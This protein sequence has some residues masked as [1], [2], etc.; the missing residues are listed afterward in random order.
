M[1]NLNYIS[2]T[3]SSK[4]KADTIKKPD[5]RID[6]FKREPLYFECLTGNSG[7]DNI[8]SEKSL[9]RPQLALAG[10]YE[11][12]SKNSVQI[13]GNTEVAYLNSLSKPKRIKSFLALVENK[14]PCIVLTNSNTLDD[15]IIDIAKENKVPIFRTEKNTNHTFIFLSEYLDDYF[16]PQQ[17]AHGTL[18]DVFGVGILFHGRAAIGKSEL[19]LALIEKGHRLVA[20]DSVILCNKRETTIMGTSSNLAKHFMEIRGVGIIDI[21]QMF[22]MKAVRFQKRVEVLVELEDWDPKDEY[23]RLGDKESYTDIMGINIPTV[24]LPISTGKNVAVL[25][26]AI[27]LNHLLRVYGYNP[28]TQFGELLKKRISSKKIDPNFN[29]DMRSVTWFQGDDE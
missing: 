19:A 3:L 18:L 16:A 24:V 15:F 17:V 9:Y 5:L 29:N 21:R 6:A 26:E 2:D 13:L 22:G 4:I 23:T 25:A 11:R 20:D 12:F 7:L 14:I 10:F 1:E 28:A 8:L 27:A